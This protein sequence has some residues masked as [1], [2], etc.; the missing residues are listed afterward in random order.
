M[1]IRN[2]IAAL[3]LFSTYGYSETN[4]PVSLIIS[5]MNATL[6]NGLLHVEF[7]NDAS[8][9]AIIKNGVNLVTS[10]SGAQ[11]DPSKTR[12]AYLDFYSKGVKDFL[13]ERLEIIRNDK[14]IVHIAW[15]DEKKSLLRLEYHLIMRRGI[16]GLY[17]YVVAENTGKQNV[18]ISELRNVYRFNPQL[19]DHI[20]NG[21][22]HGKPYLYAELEKM[23]EVQDETWQLPDGS[24][25]TKYDFAGYQRGSA[26]WGVYGKD[27]GAWLI[28]ASGEYFS[29][30]TLKQDLMVHQDAIILNYMTGAHMGTPDM[31][32]PPGWKKVYGPWLL[33]IN[34]G[35]NTQMLTD[36]GKQAATE[37]ANWPYHWVDDA[38]Y[39]DKRTQVSGSIASPTP[40][41]VVL[42]SSDEPFD[43]QTRGYLFSTA[44]DNTGAYRFE[45]VTPGQYQL[46]V[47]ATSGTQPGV[48]VQRS[49]VIEGEKQT[50][51]DITLPPSPKVLWAIGQADRQAR[52]FRF[53]NKKRGY[54][55]QN[56]VPA[57]LKFD[58]GRSDYSRDWY[59]AQTKPGNW[60]IRFTLKPDKP[61]YTLHIA[62]AAASNSGMGS[63]NSAPSLVV[64]V[65]G[66]VLDTLKYSND[67]TIYRG[68]LRNGKYHLATLPI[69]KA[70]LHNGNNTITLQL[71]GGSVMYDIITLSE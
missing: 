21:E 55:W 5:G 28:H 16:S 54:H 11:R 70:L 2:G 26:F 60:D 46:A 69:S 51:S 10:L 31:Q 22:S 42:S 27:F 8:A 9:T 3:L 24:V 56:D 18:P 40:V 58:I 39:V 49:V 4:L 45:H 7:K 34:Q 30:D 67:K 57:D 14:D 68:A 43:V 41:T 15:I 25:Y 63:S 29:G 32:A 19:L 13:P 59:Y 64:K 23:P 20:Y 33:Y 61:T 50:L 66:K 38:R 47:Y 1:H 17:S 36:A 71:N 53:G 12:S 44:T 6:D 35:N 52:E 62:L 65:N 37:R 48:L